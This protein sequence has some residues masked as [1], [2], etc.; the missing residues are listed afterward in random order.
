MNHTVQI[1]FQNERG[2]V[3]AGELVNAYRVIES[4]TSPVGLAVEIDTNDHDEIDVLVF[5]GD[6]MQAH[7]V[8]IRRV[9]AAEEVQV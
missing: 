6:D 2:D 4:A 5:H 7:H 9:I 8:S 1:D 3:L